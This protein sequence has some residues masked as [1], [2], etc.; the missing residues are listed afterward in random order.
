M[1]KTIS[2]IIEQARSGETPDID[3]ARLTICAMDAMMTFDRMAMS[4]LASG[5]TEGKKLIGSYSP[6]F[7]YEE[8]FKRL[9]RS[10]AL[11]PKEYLGPN[12]DP[13]IEENQ[14]RR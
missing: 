10:M 9:K 1:S 14:Q 13:D 7:A 6:T 8:R 11:T 3:D 2:E 4:R 5:Q 12:Y